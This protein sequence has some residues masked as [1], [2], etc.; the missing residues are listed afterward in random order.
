MN[1]PTINELEMHVNEIL[2]EKNRPIINFVSA[3]T[4]N[5]LTCILF[6]SILIIIYLL[7]IIHSLHHK[8]KILS[9][10][11]TS[12]KNIDILNKKIISNNDNQSSPTLTNL[13]STEHLTSGDLFTLHL[14][15]FAEPF[16]D[17]DTPSGLSYQNIN[18]TMPFTKNLIRN[19]DAGN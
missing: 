8:L 3:K 1:L 19:S 2:A 18:K 11:N 7:Y 5:T 13:S 16:D 9:A 17:N 12:L 15:T 14:S 10:S 4:I 6:M